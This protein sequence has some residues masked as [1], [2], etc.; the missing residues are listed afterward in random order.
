MLQLTNS[1]KKMFQISTLCLCLV[2]VAIFVSW[3][4]GRC[5]TSTSALTLRNIEAFSQDANETIQPNNKIP[6][7]TPVSCLLGDRWVKLTRIDCS[8]CAGY[9]CVPINP[10]QGN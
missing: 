7:E 6:K 9:H 8:S 5:P 3:M 1:M 2:L 10:C 4:A